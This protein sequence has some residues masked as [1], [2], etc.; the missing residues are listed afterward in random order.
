[1]DLHSING[2]D[3]SL[4]ELL[5]A[6]GCSEPASLALAD[7]DELHHELVKA[8]ELL[9]LVSEHVTREQVAEWV[10]A[11]V[12]MVHASDEQ[13]SEL[14]EDEDHDQI[15]VDYERVP[16]V[17]EMLQNAPF[18]LPLPARVLVQHEVSV[19]RIP[20]GIMLNRYVG[21]LEVRVG[22]PRSQAD[23][24][25]GGLPQRGVSGASAPGLDVLRMQALASAGSVADAQQPQRRMDLIRS[26][27]PSTNRGRNPESRWYIRGVLHS[28]PMSLY[29]AALITL[30]LSVVLPLSVVCAV[31]LVLSSEMPERFDWVSGW[32]LVV[33]GLLLLLGP[34]YLLLGLGSK[35]RV[36]S[37]RLFVHR[38]H[39]KNS[40]AHHFPGLGYVIPL[41]L[42]LL[43]FRWFR[44][45]HCGTA[46]RVKE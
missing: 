4:V 9:W 3:A 31:L 10:A 30:C 21:D 42:H 32:I 8:N 34:G 15:E 38:S 40:K 7:V 19:S 17:Q 41:C 25:P 18:A 43:V 46:S 27:H 2:L 39:I 6:A 33:P 37:Q 16:E 13:A 11:A 1:M 29:F 20:A 24:N 28:E 14:I 36:C 22:R 5:E 35:C 12:A 26:P 44:C 45:T 23:A